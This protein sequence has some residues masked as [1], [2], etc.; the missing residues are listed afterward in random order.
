[1]IYILARGYRRLCQITDEGQ[2]II[3]GFL[4][5]ADL[6]GQLFPTPKPDREEHCIEIVREAR[7]I[8][9][10]TDL[11]KM[12]L[13]GHPQFLLRLMDILEIRQHRWER[14]VLSLV[15]KDVYAQTAKILIELSEAFGEHCQDD[16]DCVRHIA[17]THQE[18]SDLVGRPVSRSASLSASS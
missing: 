11:F 15:S 7:I 18:I 16:P 6:F 4:G 10:E 2:R 17:L 8:G 12:I 3:A 9:V 14:R 13:Q 5:P 1:M